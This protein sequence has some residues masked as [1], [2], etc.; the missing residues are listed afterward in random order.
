MFSWLGSIF[1]SCRMVMPTQMTMKPMTRVRIW[2]A[3]AES[4]LKRTMVVV[5]EKKVTA[6]DDSQ[7][8]SYWERA[9]TYR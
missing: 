5:M 7:T 3:G 2:L 8:S 9:A 4:P 6:V 1:D